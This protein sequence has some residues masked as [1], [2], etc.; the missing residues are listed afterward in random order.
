MDGKVAKK[1]KKRQ[2]NKSTYTNERI[3]L[4]HPHFYWS[5]S[6]CRTSWWEKGRERESSRSTFF[7]FFLLWHFLI[8]A[9]SCAPLKYSW[10]KLNSLCWRAKCIKQ[11]QKKGR[12]RTR[13]SVFFSPD[14][15][16]HRNNDKRM[17]A[18][19]H[20][21]LQWQ[22]L[23]N[24]CGPKEKN[25]VAEL[26]FEMFILLLLREGKIKR[27][28]RWFSDTIEW[29][30]GGDGRDRETE[31]WTGMFCWNKEGRTDVNGHVR[32]S[33]VSLSLCLS[34][35][36]VSPSMSAMV[37]LSLTLS[38]SLSYPLFFCWQWERSKRDGVQ[39]I[40][41]KSVNATQQHDHPLFFS[42]AKK[43]RQK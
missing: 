30:N 17:I 32:M 40:D 3:E 33:L 2:T 39:R 24:R 23:A 20:V 16:F 31:G 11:Q 25:R 12:G 26:D 29:R 18:T 10:K 34:F 8:L 5:S 22:G 41:G 37:H 6:P 7:F 19:I 1:Y 4:E 28:G 42:F 36:S 38:L 27:R 35:F 13:I 21:H 9:L 14:S 15:S 43:K